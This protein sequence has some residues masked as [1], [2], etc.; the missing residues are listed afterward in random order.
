MVKKRLVGVISVLDGWAVQ[1]FGFGR[2][3]P[4]GKPECLVENLG[5]WGVDE[6]LVLA[7][8]RSKSGDGPDLQLLD[9]LSRVGTSTPLIYGGGIRDLHDGIE[10]IQRGADRI[11]VDALLRD[12]LSAVHALSQNLGSQAVIASM[13]LSVGT[14]GLEWLDYRTMSRH[15]VGTLLD[16]AIKSSAISEVLLIDW[17]HEGLSG[18]FDAALIERF[19]YPSVPLIVFGGISEP[20]QVRGLVAQPNVAAVAIG[21]FLSYREHAIQQIKSQVNSA[22]LRPAT[23]AGEHSLIAHD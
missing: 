4:L 2:Y 15:P 3:L 20:N 19:P 21:N 8:D 1:S 9:K 22:A 17:M 16:T 11:C 10:V 5:R 13:P 14:A 12:D 18:A 7:I 23:F 6:I